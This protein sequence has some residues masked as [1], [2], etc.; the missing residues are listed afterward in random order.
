MKHDLYLYLPAAAVSIY[1]LRLLPITLLQKP[2]K[3]VFIRSFLYYI[4]YVTL[5]IMVFPAILGATQSI[6][7]GLAALVV[8][9]VVAY[10][11]GNLFKVAAASCIAVFLVELLL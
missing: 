10:V 11:D 3:S 6:Y 2:I 5:S 8:G 9:A 4:P 1:L 7:S